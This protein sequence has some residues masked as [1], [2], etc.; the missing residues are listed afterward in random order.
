MTIIHGVSVIIL[1]LSCVPNAYSY[2][3]HS[4]VLDVMNGLAEN[5]YICLTAVEGF[6]ADVPVKDKATETQLVGKTS[7]RWGPQG[8]I[9]SKLCTKDIDSVAVDSDVKGK[10]MLVDRGGCFFS[11]K[12]HVAQK[13][14]AA[15]MIIVNNVANP[16]RMKSEVAHDIKIPLCSIGSED[17]EKIRQSLTDTTG[18]K[19]KLYHQGQITLD[20]ITHQKAG[21][22]LTIK[23]KTQGIENEG[24]LKVNILLLQGRIS[25]A[26]DFIVKR[27]IAKDIPLTSK[28]GT[29]CGEFYCVDYQI[30]NDITADKN[31]TVQI[32]VSDD[33]SIMHGSP[34]YFAID[35][36]SDF[37]IFIK[38]PNGPVNWK[39][40]DEVTVT[41]EFQTE[42]DTKNDDSKFSILLRRGKC[43][44][45]SACNAE[46]M[47]YS[48]HKMIT[49]ASGLS[50]N[51]DQSEPKNDKKVYK[52][53]YKLRL[54]DALSGSGTQ[55]LEA[56]NWYELQIKNKHATA[57][58]WFFIT[59]EGSITLI[60]DFS[61]LPLASPVR[62]G[63]SIMLEWRYTGYISA[64]N[65]NLMTETGVSKQLIGNVSHSEYCSIDHLKCRMRWTVDSFV[66]S[67]TTPYFIEV[68]SAMDATIYTKLQEN[69][70]Y[71]HDKVGKYCTSQHVVDKSCKDCPAGKAPGLA[72]NDKSG[73]DT[74]CVDAAKAP[75]PAPFPTGAGGVHFALEAANREKN[76]A[77]CR[78]PNP[79]CGY[80]HAQN[81]LDAFLN[82]GEK[83]CDWSEDPSKYLHGVMCGQYASCFFDGC[84]ST[85]ARRKFTLDWMADDQC[86]TDH[87]TDGICCSESTCNNRGKCVKQNINGNNVYKCLCAAGS[88]GPN[89]DGTMVPVPTQKAPPNAD[90]GSSGNS[91]NVGG[92]IVVVILLVIIVSV[93]IW[94][95]QQIC[96][97]STALKNLNRTT[98]VGVGHYGDG[99][100][101]DGVEMQMKPG[102][103]A[104]PGLDANN[105]FPDGSETRTN[106]F[107]GQGK[108]YY[109][110]DDIGDTVVNL[111]QDSAYLDFDTSNGAAISDSP[112][113]G[114]NVVG[115]SNNHHDNH[116][117]V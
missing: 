61:N 101:F 94:K 114:A 7:Q 50:P 11:E 28:T 93:S 53:S 58:S 21:D 108:Q 81:C 2:T 115:V 60:S 27:S 95:R 57:T 78:P 29:N 34:Y 89:C 116:V 8:T 31:Y 30:P 17:G 99:P 19:A 51:M 80:L 100:G 49:L 52:Q 39:N 38:S 69:F 106:H 113:R 109:E 41:W 32:Y 40:N 4:A 65:V 102:G 83:K 82:K 46:K 84:N 47:F 23:W 42:Q 62:D 20:D 73:P 85:E 44:D 36:D 25:L 33:R 43:T 67:G 87:C 86:W 16:L 48:E 111:D 92:I 79:D 74:P 76:G 110:D 97:A 45:R 26:D 1:F 75:K 91:G 3:Q 68:S 9:D 105:D 6:G 66:V 64:F 10:I 37:Q 104:M 98:T 117:A 35:N 12:A 96:R 72:L 107:Q 15:A 18:P 24:N 77:T 103:V 70:F 13:L 90:D 63:H 54:R 55:E 14:G 71:V 5:K 88:E 22:K 112:R 59:V 56:S